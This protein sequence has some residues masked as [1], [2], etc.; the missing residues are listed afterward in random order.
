MHLR[1]PSVYH[2][3][4]IR[5]ILKHCTY[6]SWVILDLDNTVFRSL[7]DL[8][9]DQW[10]TRFFEYATAQITPDKD[11]AFILVITVYDA[12]QH[13]VSQIPVE[14][15]IVEIIRRL[16]DI[17]VPVLGLTARSSRIS[18][19]TLQ[20]LC[21]NGIDFSRCWGNYHFN[22]APEGNYTP[23]FHD[24]VIF[25][26]SLNKGKC[27]K[28]FSA[29]T[30]LYPRAVVMADD[31]E[32]NLHA[33]KAAQEETGGSFVG[34]RYGRLDDEVAALDLRKATIELSKISHLL[35]EEAR[36]AI[37]KLNISAILDCL[38]SRSLLGPNSLFSQKEKVVCQNRHE[39]HQSVLTYY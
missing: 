12:V 30:G 7:Q 36:A 21:E 27:L 15:E 38:D 2:S 34:I 35:P 8:G 18:Q 17:G 5:E 9:S 13:H 24:G 39:N 20:Q 33:V 11:E 22:L 23:V 28:S 14:L 3:N 25:C 10:Y 4:N 37:A 32:K 29:S 16:Q 31:K 6:N 26:N 19:R 1:S